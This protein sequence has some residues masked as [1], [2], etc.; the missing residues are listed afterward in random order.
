MTGWIKLHRKIL[1]SD[2]YNFSNA[3]QRDV[4]LQILLSTN[5]KTKNWEWNDEI[6]QRRQSQFIT[7]LEVLR[8]IRNQCLECVC[9]CQQ[10]L[11]PTPVSKRSVR[12]C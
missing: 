8:A 12:L 7:S 2:M 10:R 6:F 1:D 5:H 11:Q 3:K 9:W 4:T